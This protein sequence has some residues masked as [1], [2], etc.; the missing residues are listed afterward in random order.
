MHAMP[1]AYHGTFPRTVMKL[2]DTRYTYYYSMCQVVRY[3]MGDMGM[4]HL[5]KFKLNFWNLPFGIYFSLDSQF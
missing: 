4:G 3:H 2:N 1:L 5:H